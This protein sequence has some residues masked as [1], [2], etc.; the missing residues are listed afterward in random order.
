MLGIR[1]ISLGQHLNEGDPIVPLQ[2]LDP[3]YVNFT[4][5][6]QDAAEVH[7]GT[8]V[9]VAAD[10]TTA[11]DVSGRVTAVN[12]VIDENT[13]NV[14]VQATIPNPGHRLKPGMF[15]DV[16]VELVTHEHVIGL[17]AS[18]IKYAPYGNSATW[19]RR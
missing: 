9:H 11:R 6:Q 5:T 3:L 18:A 1:E 2:S 15:V 19:S 10:T 4:L 17:P 7:A 14:T 13:R 16:S 12:S 8:L